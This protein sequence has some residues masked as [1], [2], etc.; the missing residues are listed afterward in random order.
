MVVASWL[1]SNPLTGKL[2]TGSASVTVLQPVATSPSLTQ[3]SGG[4]Q[5]AG[6]IENGTIAGQGLATVNST[7]PTGNVQA[8]SGFPVPVPCPTSNP[9]CN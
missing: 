3:A 1:P 6:S 5:T 2:T 8:R 4:I 9:N 7:D